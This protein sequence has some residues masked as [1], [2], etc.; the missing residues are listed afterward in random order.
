[1][2]N[3]LNSAYIPYH[4]NDDEYTRPAHARVAK[5]SRDELTLP[6]R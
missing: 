4:V 3:L 5:H 2:I 6:P 1:M